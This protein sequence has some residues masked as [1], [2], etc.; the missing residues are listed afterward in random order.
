VKSHGYPV[1]AMYSPELMTRGDSCNLITTLSSFAAVL[2]V[3]LITMASDTLA[4]SHEW[5]SGDFNE[6]KVKGARRFANA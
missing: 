3:T 4:P 6:L 1:F 5:Q 2:S